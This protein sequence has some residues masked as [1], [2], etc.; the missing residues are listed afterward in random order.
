MDMV[1][2]CATCEL[3][4][5]EEAGVEVETERKELVVLIGAALVL[6]VFVFV[7]VFVFAANG[8]SSGS[9]ACCR[10]MAARRAFRVVS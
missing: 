7:L 2:V 9:V 1:A 6:L 10:S 5:S 3:V 4:V 8:L